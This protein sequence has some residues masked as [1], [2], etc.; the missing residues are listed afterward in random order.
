MS[1]GYQIDAYKSVVTALGI[2]CYLLLL[3]A[4]RQESDTPTLAFSEIKTWRVPIDGPQL[5]APRSVACSPTDDSVVVLDNAGRVLV[6]DAHGKVIRRWMMPDI[7][8]GR[9]EGVVVLKD[10]RVVVCD[11]HYSRIIV[12]D[13]SGKILK[14]FG[15]YGREPGQFVYPVAI[16]T[17][18]QE[19][20]YI[21]EYGDNDR[22]QKFTTA[23]E[24]L[25]NFG[26]FAPSPDSFSAL[27]DCLDEW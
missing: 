10:S 21:G 17:D 16:T 23:G 12:F 1:G 26:S 13:S 24:L 11:T 15:S 4:C 2:V 27:W 3:T 18:A 6:Y 9:P 8:V 7:E 19:N 14:M 5:P 20:L 22:I 25:G